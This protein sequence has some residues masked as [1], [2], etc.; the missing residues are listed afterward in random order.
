MISDLKIRQILIESMA[1]KNANSECKKV[2]R[3]LKARSVAIDEWIIK[4]G[5]TGSHTYDNT[6][7]GEVIS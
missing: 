7:T 5:D 6:W 4:T 3:P 2:I 1:F